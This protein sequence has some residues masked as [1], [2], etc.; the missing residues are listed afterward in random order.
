M[1]LQALNSRL[2]ERLKTLQESAQRLILEDLDKALEFG[3][4]SLEL[5][6]ELGNQKDIARSQDILGTIHLKKQ[7]FT[8]ALELLKKSVSGAK[9]TGDKDILVSS[10][11]KT[12]FA[13]LE[14]E[15]YPQALDYFLKSLKITEETGDQRLT[16]SLYNNIGIIYNQLNDLP[17]ALKYYSM[18][19][20]INERVNNQP[21]M[22]AAYNNIAIIYYKQGKYR[23]SET[24]YSESLDLAERLGDHTGIARI[25]YNL[26]KLY[27]DEKEFSKSRSYYSKIEQLDIEPAISRGVQAARLLGLGKCD[28]AQ[29]KYEQAI[30]NLSQALETASEIESLE[31]QRDAADMLG[32]VYHA[33]GRYQEAYQMKLIYEENHE[34]LL[35]A[36]KI[37]K[38]AQLAQQYE[39]KKKELEKET[40]IRRQKFLFIIVLI[41]FLCVSMS[42]LIL[43][44]MFM[45]KRSANRQLNE[46]NSTKDKFFSIIAHDLKK[47]FSTLIGFLKILLTEFDTYEKKKIK[48]LLKTVQKTSEITY[49]LLEN[50]LLWAN[51]QTG[52]IELTPET[53]NLR[54]TVDSVLALFRLYADGKNIELHNGIPLN[55]VITADRK[56]VRLILRNL[57]SNAIKFTPPGG[58]VTLQATNREGIV[59]VKVRDNGVGIAPGDID[60]LFKIDRTYSTPGTANEKGTGLGLVLCKEFL[61]KA[62]G[63]IRVDSRSGKGSVFTVS[64]DTP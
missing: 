37:K 52:R 14:M 22:A 55:T 60:N 29:R 49:E 15:N 48:E 47:P 12:G 24:Y 58:K 8:K 23:L 28:F 63:T 20:Q 19:L 61:D 4:K 21:L 38:L 9:Q 51:I 32:K 33:L 36:T 41:A 45:I 6:I 2:E 18:S 40:E 3:E 5:A 62:G 27:F 54:H 13:S 59:E 64:L 17:N 44:K 42:L 10:Y 39:F 57:V 26:G 11:F 34:K 56:I 46:L 1:P 25:Y 35:D 7:N 50:L 43:V 53:F 16:G 30:R 31:V